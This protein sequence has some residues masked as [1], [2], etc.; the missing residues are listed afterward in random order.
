MTDEP[1]VTLPRHRLA[2]LR[3]ALTSASE[4]QFAAA[5]ELLHELSDGELGELERVVRSFV[6]DFQISVEQSAL[7]IEEFEVSK[8]ELYSKIDEIEEQRVA[9]LRLSAPII[10]IWEGVVTV[11]LVGKL[12]RERIDD[13]QERLLNSLHSTGSKWVILDL[14]GVALLDGDSGR[15]LVGIAR[16]IGLM[17]ATCVLT[18]ISQRVALTLVTSEITLEGLEIVS[19]LREGLRYCLGRSS[20]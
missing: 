4:G 12:D 7:S 9:I 10:D 16:A 5:L 20:D 19:T 6:R 13:L 2:R 17:G 1:L 18:G 3:R 11:P 15:S 14:T 8:R